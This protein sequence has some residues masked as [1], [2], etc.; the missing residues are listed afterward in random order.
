MSGN[1]IAV[2]WILFEPGKP[3][4]RER[5]GL[6]DGIDENKNV[7]GRQRAGR[8]AY[9]SQPVEPI[10]EWIDHSPLMHVTFPQG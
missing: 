3:F 8:S 6:R 10:E 7:D 4:W 1:S 5:P 2:C 9:I